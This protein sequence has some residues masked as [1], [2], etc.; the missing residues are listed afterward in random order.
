[1]QVR[2][3]EAELPTR[4]RNITSNTQKDEAKRFSYNAAQYLPNVYRK[5][6]KKKL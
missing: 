6:M 2:S 1:M 4:S 5:K 3:L